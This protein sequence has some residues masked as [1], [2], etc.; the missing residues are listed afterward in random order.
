MKNWLKKGFTVSRTISALQNLV[1]GGRLS[2]RKNRPGSS[3]W[4]NGFTLIELLIVIAIVGILTALVTTNLQGARSRAR[5]VRRKSD[6]R[7]IEQSLRLYY[8]DA[9]S[10]P[11]SSGAY[12]INGCGTISTPTTCSWSGSF[13]TDNDIYMSSLPQDPSSSDTPISYRYYSSNDDQYILVAELENLSDLDIAASQARCETV[14]G[15]FTGAK[16]TTDY[17]IC[18]Q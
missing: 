10:F 3:V 11:A 16:T 6:L 8:N 7:A 17:V 18:A 13:A 2:Q 5:D 14:Y 1:G 9:K 15:T 12:E 4:R